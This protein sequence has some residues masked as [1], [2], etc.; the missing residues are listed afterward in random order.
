MN[1]A[2]FD[3]YPELTEIQIFRGDTAIY[4]KVITEDGENLFNLTR[5]LK[6][7]SLEEALRLAIEGAE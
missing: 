5:A 7:N 6:S 2:L 4:C 3:Q 1:P